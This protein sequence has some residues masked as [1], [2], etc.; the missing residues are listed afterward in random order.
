MYSNTCSL[1][2]FTPE[3]AASLALAW[4][5]DNINISPLLP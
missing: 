2:E 3:I 5:L 4:L 1:T